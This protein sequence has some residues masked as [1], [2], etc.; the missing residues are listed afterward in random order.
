MNDIVFRAFPKPYVWIQRE[1][2][3]ISNGYVYDPHT[4]EMFE[5]TS[6]PYV[7]YLGRLPA[8]ADK[9]MELV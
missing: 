3:S 8:V 4:G 5:L 6:K 7:N 1:C 2:W 9:Q